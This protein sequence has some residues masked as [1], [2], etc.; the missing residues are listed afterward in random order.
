MAPLDGVQE[1]NS[2]LQQEEHD[3]ERQLI[4]GRKKKHFN[5]YHNS[6]VKL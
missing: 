2:L 1:E 5:I 4:S 6:K 3:K